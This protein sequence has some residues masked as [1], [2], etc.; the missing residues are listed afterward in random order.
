MKTYSDAECLSVN[1]FEGDFG[2]PQDTVLSDK[3][4]SA[5]KQHE[6]GCCKSRIEKGERYRSLSAIFDGDLKSY[7]FCQL[8]CQAMAACF[9]DDG[10]AWEARVSLGNSRL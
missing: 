5:R 1:P 6:C 9:D 3:I 4:V 7:K 2:D 10:K 8:C